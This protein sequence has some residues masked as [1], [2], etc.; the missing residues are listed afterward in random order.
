MKRGQLGLQAAG[1]KDSMRWSQDQST[2]KMKDK[3]REKDKN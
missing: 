1:A 2:T 3:K